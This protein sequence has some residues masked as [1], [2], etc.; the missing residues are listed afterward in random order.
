MKDN[1]EG[2]FM[3]NGVI[4]CKANFKVE[5]KNLHCPDKDFATFSGFAST[6]NNIDLDHDI[7]ARG[8]FLKTLQSD[9]KVKLLWQHNHAEI[10]G[11]FLKLVE[12]EAGLEV[13]GRLNLGTRRGME[14]IALLRAGDLDSMS[15][16]FRVK[17]DEFDPDTG[18]RILKELELLE[19]SLVSMPANPL[20]VVTDVKSI[21][22]MEKIADVSG[23]LKTVGL[24][25]KEIKKLISKIKTFSRQDAGEEELK[26]K[27]QDVVNVEANQAKLD[28]TVELMKSFNNQFKG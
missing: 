20:A 25:N 14:A 12:T 22:E 5:S 7:I 11:S 28:E 9:R 23:F 17:K 6:F 13:E 8:A 16:G 24:S 26:H 27:E 2:I 19:I 1:Q 18:I 4:V 3:E 21:E 10:I 15:I